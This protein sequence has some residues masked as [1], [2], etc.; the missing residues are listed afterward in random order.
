MPDLELRLTLDKT[1][2]A[3]NGVLFMVADFYNKDG[4]CGG[5]PGADMYEFDINA[6]GTKPGTTQDATPS[7]TAKPATGNTHANP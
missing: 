5:T 4:V 6:A 3:G 7:Q 1:T 2:P